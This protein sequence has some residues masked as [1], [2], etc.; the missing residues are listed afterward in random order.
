MNENFP[1]WEEFSEQKLH[2]SPLSRDVQRFELPIHRV[3]LSTPLHGNLL[4]VTLIGAVLFLGYKNREMAPLLLYGAIGVASII[5]LGM[6]FRDGLFL[7]LESRR[8]KTDGEMINQ[9]TLGP[10]MEQEKTGLFSR[11]LKK[12]HNKRVFR[13]KLFQI[14]YQN[15]LRTFEQGNRRTWV[16]QE[17][18]ISD[19][20]TLL[21]QH[22]MKVAWTVIEVLPQLGLIGTLVGLTHMFSSFGEGVANPELGILAGF[23]TA[24][25]TTIVANLVVLVLRPLYMR[26]ERSMNEILNTMQMLMAMFILP[27]QQAVLDRSQGHGGHASSASLMPSHGMGSS[28]ADPRLSQSVDHLTQTL[29]QI[30]ETQAGLD[31][32]QMAQETAKVAREVQVMLRQFTDSVD[33]RQL[34]RQQQ[35]FLKFSDSVDKLSG[36]LVKLGQI[37]SGGSMGNQRIEHDLAQLRVLN[38][39]TLLLLDQIAG[40]LNKLSGEHRTRLSE[41]PKLR[42]QIFSEKKSTE[43]NPAGKE[44]GT[45]RV[46]PKVR[47]FEDGQ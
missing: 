44:S 41:N 12:S 33:P 18:S 20:H 19:I 2:D 32:G 13:S 25:G 16:S 4:Y 28:G 43:G 29:T 42:E 3:Y 37:Q 15:V 34:E 39:D 27:T 46:D 22:G 14:H 9:D 40:Q 21:T 24:L 10:K 7:H 8:L 30:M 6:L 31:S 35:M 36:N 1:S 38:H 5:G 45:R 11:F 17:A 47:M 23:G 26:N